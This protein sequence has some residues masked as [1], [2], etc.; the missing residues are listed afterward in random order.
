MRIR[1]ARRADAAAVNELLDQLG[2]PQDGPA[3]T[4]G[5]IESWADDA[6][7][8][9]YVA[10]A[11]DHLLGLIAVHICPFFERAGS[12]GRIV[13]LVVS[14]RAR[15]RGV[16]TR[17]VAAAESFAAAHGCVRMEVTSSDR[18]HEAH[19]FYRH[20]GYL[21][22]AGTSSRFRRDLP[23]LSAQPAPGREP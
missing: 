17:L 3:A 20:R 12:W 2:Y 4:A 23:D 21:D 15:G 10:E 13:A 7:S 11:G 19:A 8:A 18:R 16:G 9:A 1:P 14:D 6:A 5:R 22:L